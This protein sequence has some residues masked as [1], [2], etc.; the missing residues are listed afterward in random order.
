MS[1]SRRARPLLVALVALALA[2]GCGSGVPPTDWAATVCGTLTPWRATVT[3]LNRQAQQRLA[4]ATTPEQTRTELLT[5]LTGAKDAT[6]QARARI[7][8]AGEPDVDGGPDAAQQFVASL[9]RVR[10]SYAHAA[11][12]LQAIPTTDPAYYDRVAE[13][14]TMLNQEYAASGVDPAKLNSPDLQ[15]AFAG[16]SQ[17]Q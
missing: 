17:C 14:L 16:L 7:A 1:S 8:G 4:L 12:A 13:V 10:D 5:L 9:E 15:K 6:E 11:A 2:A 3:G